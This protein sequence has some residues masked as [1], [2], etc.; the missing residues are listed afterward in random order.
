MIL[1][2]ITSVEQ[3]GAVDI[4]IEPPGFGT[5]EQLLRSTFSHV[6]DTLHFLLA[7]PRTS[8]VIM[9]CCMCHCEGYIFQTVYSRITYRN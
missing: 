3:L 6:E 4:V 2:I 9:S 8:A 1:A 5:I 7:I